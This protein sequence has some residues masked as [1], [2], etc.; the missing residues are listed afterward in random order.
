MVRICGI[1][2]QWDI[3]IVAN[4]FEGCIKRRIQYSMSIITENKNTV[5]VSM[6]RRTESENDVLFDPAHY[7]P[8]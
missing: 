3:H 5:T 7:S 8:L 6:I 1:V 2:R 4:G